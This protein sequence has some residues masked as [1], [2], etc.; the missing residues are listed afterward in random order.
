[1][2]IN[3]DDT[4]QAKTARIEPHKERIV[5]PRPTC[6]EQGKKRLVIFGRGASDHRAGSFDPCSFGLIRENR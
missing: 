4:D 5:A 1:V 6:E 2:R 3:K